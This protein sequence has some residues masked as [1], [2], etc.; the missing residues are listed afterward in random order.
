MGGAH[1]IVTGEVGKAED[2]GE[3]E[4]EWGNGWRERETKI[5]IGGKKVVGEW[6]Q[7]SSRKTKQKILTHGN[8]RNSICLVFPSLTKQIYCL[9]FL[10]ARSPK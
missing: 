9:I 5:R 1:L 2:M 6:R 4:D 7:R 8:I 3:K 10:K